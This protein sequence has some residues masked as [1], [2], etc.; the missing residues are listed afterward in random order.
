M[1]IHEGCKNISK[2]GIYQFS[3]INPVK[4]TGNYKFSKRNPNQKATPDYD[5]VIKRLH[6]YYNMKT[7]YFRN[8]TKDRNFNNTISNFLY[9]HIHKQPLILYQLE[10]SP[11]FP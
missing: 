10:N 3:L 11:S 7:S 5:I 9:S 4:M 1:Y 2:R 6:L 8:R